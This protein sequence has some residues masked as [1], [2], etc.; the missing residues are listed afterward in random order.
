MKIIANKNQQRLFSDA[1]DIIEDSIKGLLKKQEKV[2]MGLPG[3]RSM[4]G[5]FSE[6]KKKEIPWKNA[7]IFMIDERLVPIDDKDSNF[8]LIN[9]NLICGLKIP[10]ANIHPFVVEKGIQEYEHELIKH[11]GAYDITVLSAGED[12]HIGALYPNHHSIEDDSEYFIIMHD[13]PKLPKERMSCSRKLLA[14]SKVAILLFIGEGKK[15]A[16]EK[17]KGKA[18]FN[19]LPAKL[20]EAIEDSYVLTD[21]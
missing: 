8:R 15:R 2:V 7:H 6:L 10:K 11:G 5:L 13:S 4:P 1:A 19:E 17:F 18:D 16:F 20:V 3:G 14:R 12:G 9:D 21:L